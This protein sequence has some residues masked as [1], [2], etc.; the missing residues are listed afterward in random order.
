[1]PI[2]DDISPPSVTFR[3]NK[4]FRMNAVQTVNRAEQEY[5]RMLNNFW[6]NETLTPQEVADAIGTDAADLINF[7]VALRT[8]ILTV[9]PGS[10]IPNSSSYGT[11]TMN[12]DGTITAV[13]K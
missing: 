4:S 5:I 6:H 10:S 3:I 7:I 8:F 1:M 13:P 12:G 9:K 2:L 11:I